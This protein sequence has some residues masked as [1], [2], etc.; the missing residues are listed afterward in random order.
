VTRAK[1]QAVPSRGPASDVRALAR[2]ASGDLGALGELYDTFAPS[3]LRFAV[4]V[5]G[6]DDAEDIVQ[7]VFVRVARVAHTF[8]VDA[9]TAR[10]WLFAI[11]ARVALERRRSL[12][13]FAVARLRLS[14]HTPPSG[15]G[16]AEARS[17]VERALAR[18]PAAKRTVLVLAE[19]EG[20]TCDEIA[21][22]L[23]I[24][25]G[26]VWTRLHHARRELRRF[27]DEDV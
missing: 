11:T 7:T 3:L 19:V 13:R 10:P 18:L 16:Y 20:F 14:A 6:R 24:P 23:E 12:R 1:L 22:M 27:C 26:T 15:S 2:V 9:P 5:A 17:D 25:V 21:S 8:D 4:R